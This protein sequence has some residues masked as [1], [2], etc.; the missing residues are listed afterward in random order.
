MDEVAER[1]TLGSPEQIFSRYLLLAPMEGSCD[2][3]SEILLLEKSFSRSISQA[4][5]PSVGNVG[6]SLLTMKLATSN[7]LSF[8][9]PFVDRCVALNQFPLAFDVLYKIFYFYPTGNRWKRSMIAEKHLSIVNGL[10]TISDFYRAGL[11]VDIAG[12]ACLPES[13][14]RSLASEKR[15]KLE[16]VISSQTLSNE[17]LK[18]GIDISM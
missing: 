14:G 16:K 13:E 5:N 3:F 12:D 1:L 2:N 11:A 15:F 4:A 7:L 17:L 10:I 18:Q 8:A 6:S 9:F